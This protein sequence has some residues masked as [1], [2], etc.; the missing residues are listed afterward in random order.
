M[1]KSAPAVV[2][3]AVSHLWP[4]ISSFDTWNKF[5][6][7]KRP[8]LD[9]K[10]HDSVVVSIDDKLG[11]DDSMSAKMAHITRPVLGSSQ[12]GSMNDKL[13]RLHI[14]SGGSL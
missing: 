5:E 13:V 1:I 4:D 7:I 11:I 2:L 14:K 3:G 9:H 10:R 6:I 8:E 12:S